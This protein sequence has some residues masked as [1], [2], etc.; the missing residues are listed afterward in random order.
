[1]GVSR[2]GYYA[3]LKRPESRRA[4]ADR[5]LVERIR[6]IHSDSHGCYGSPRVY[7]ALRQQG[8]PVG[9]GRVERLMREAGLVG[10]VTKLYRRV[11]S[12]ERFYTRFGNLRLKAPEP[13]HPNEQWVADLTYIRVANE[14][15]YL[16]V[17]MDLFSR[18]IIGWSLGKYKTAELTLRALKQA[19]KTRNPAPGLIFHTDRGVEYGAHLIQN[20]LQRHG[21]QPSMNRPRH[22]TDNAHM[23]SFFHS[24]KAE[25]LH[26][27]HFRDTQ[28]L[29]LALLAYIDPFYNRIRLH[30]GI[31]YTS[32]IKYERV[33]A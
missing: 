18:R 19:L 32:P 30:S 23:E 21:I 7:Q 24:L 20:E 11:P 8:C 28:T 10:K 29:R 25:R 15:N 1:L 22:C 6:Q 33:M 4:Q 27:E 2:S 14:W 13:S 16:A 31:G 3:W 12:I 9:K 5:Q 26:G 17:V